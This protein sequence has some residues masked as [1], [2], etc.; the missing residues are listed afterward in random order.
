LPVPVAPGFFALD[1]AVFRCELAVVFVFVV[2]FAA[3]G[4]AEEVCDFAAGLHIRQSAQ[5]AAMS[6]V[7]ERVGRDIS[8]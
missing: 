3:G 5:L 4:A 1:E 7:F 8:K 6:A 2:G